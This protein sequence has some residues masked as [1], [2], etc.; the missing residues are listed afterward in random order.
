MI[1]SSYTDLY[2]LD[3]SIFYLML[4]NTEDVFRR[5]DFCK[6][7][8]MSIKIVHCSNLTIVLIII[9]KVYYDHIHKVYMT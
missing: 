6:V 3:T 9:I 2:N 1:Q 7:T 5:G 4:F 8:E